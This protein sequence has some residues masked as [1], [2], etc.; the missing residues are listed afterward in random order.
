VFRA[1]YENE[2]SGR[3]LQWVHSLGDAVVKG[4]FG[5]KKP[6]EFQLSTL[7][8]AALLAFNSPGQDCVSVSYNELSGA[9]Q[10]PEEAL[11]R[12]LHSLACGKYK[13]LK[14][15]GPSN[16]IKSSDVFTANTKFRLC[17]D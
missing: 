6:Y 15:D 5:G 13:I 17:F 16:A 7:Q 11:K 12:V 3:R 1:F 2:T 4:Y 8:A 14:K 10:L 9:L